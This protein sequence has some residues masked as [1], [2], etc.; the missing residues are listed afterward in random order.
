MNIVDKYNL[1]IMREKTR[2]KKDLEK[3]NTYYGRKKYYPHRMDEWKKDGVK[4]EKM[5]KEKIKSM[6]VKLKELE[7]KLLNAENKG[8]VCAICLD[9]MYSL[10]GDAHAVSFN[11]KTC[12]KHIFHYG[13]V[14]DGRVKLCPICRNKNKNLT[15]IDVEKLSVLNSSTRRSSSS[16]KK[17]NRCPKGTRKNKKTGKC[18]KTVK[19]SG[20]KKR[21][22]NGTRRDKKTGE[23]VKK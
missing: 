17:G 10:E 21:C 1:E 8:P 18:E 4:M 2:M 23:C 7:S 14:S 19:S 5:Q 22:A 11:N 6:E 16:K 13:C 9:N 12:K 15:H 3:H 20:T